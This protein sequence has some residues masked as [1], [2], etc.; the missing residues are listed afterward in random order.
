MLNSDMF[1]RV[2]SDINGN[3]RYV[4]HF[5]HLLRKVDREDTNVIGTLYEIALRNAKELGGKKFHNKQ[6]GG[7]IVFSS[8]NLENLCES[9]NLL[10]GKLI[11]GHREPTAIELKRGYGAI[12]YKTFVT[13][14][15][16]KKDG[17]IKKWCKCPIDGLNYSFR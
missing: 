13:A 12:H 3:P 9:I 14:D 10:T 11:E 1:T 6:Y 17:S 2:N 15:V 8:Y 7:G 16:T 4:C 5:L